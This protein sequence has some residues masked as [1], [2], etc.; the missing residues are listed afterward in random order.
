MYKIISKNLL[1]LAISIF[2]LIVYSGPGS[3]SPIPIDTIHIDSVSPKT[4]VDVKLG[5]LGDQMEYAGFYNV[6]MNVT[7]ASEWTGTQA[8]FCVEDAWGLALYGNNPP[9]TNYSLYD[10]PS[11]S[12][13]YEAALLM[14]NYYAQALTGDYD[15]LQIAIWE[16]VLDPGSY[17]LTN[18]NFIL[19]QGGNTPAGTGTTA[20][21]WLNGLN[22][23]SFSGDYIYKIASDDA[24][25]PSSGNQDLIVRTSASVPEP[26]TI[27]LLGTGLIG[28]AGARRKKK[29][30]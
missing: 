15:E 30:A 14:D 21:T 11:N 1:V 19:Y 27:L 5:D 29:K 17:D 26:A 3:A 7:S 25:T 10:I 22:S 23:L 8:T 2:L 9:A 18:G 6:T 4:N 12:G 24:L 13:Y 20:S 16:A 28:L